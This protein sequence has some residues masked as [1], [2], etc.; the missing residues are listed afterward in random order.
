MS[1]NALGARVVLAD[2]RLDRFYSNLPTLDLLDARASATAWGSATE[3]RRFSDHVPVTLVFEPPRSAPTRPA[4]IPTWVARD[5]RILARVKAELEFLEG[6][7]AHERLQSFL[8]IAAACHAVFRHELSSRIATTDAERLHW[9]AIAFRAGRASD[10]RGV[11]RALTAYS[12]LAPFVRAD[13]FFVLD[14]AGLGEHLAACHRRRIA[15]GQAEHDEEL[16][17][18]NALRGDA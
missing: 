14:F 17:T 11:R 2:A 18:K 15:Q 9:T 5:P 7:S 3:H 16:G 10:R 12:G 4:A 6:D 1:R 13:S 8:S